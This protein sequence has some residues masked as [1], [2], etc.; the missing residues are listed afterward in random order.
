MSDICQKIEIKRIAHTHV[1]SDITNF[2]SG[3]TSIFFDL[4]GV[5][6]GVADNRYVTLSGDVMYGPLSSPTLSTNNLYVKENALFFFNNS[7]Q[8][9][10]NLKGSDVTSFRYATALVNSTSADWLT[11]N[12]G[13]IEGVYGSI[14]ATP[15]FTVDTKGRIVS[16]TNIINTITE[17]LI[18]ALAIAL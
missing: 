17:D 16:A 7:N 11:G 3:V 12:S 5:T 18:I 9:S 8:I 13:V 6:Y 2:T 4:S 1:V 15:S 10:E 14:S